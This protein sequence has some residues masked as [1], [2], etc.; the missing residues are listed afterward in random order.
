[1][2]ERSRVRAIV[3]EYQRA[4]LDVLSEDLDFVMLYG[5]RA[6][7]DDVEGSDIDVLCVMKHP[8]DYGELIRRTSEITGEISLKYGVVL[9]RVF[10]SREDYRAKR[11]PFL[12]NVHKDQIAI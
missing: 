12:V 5:S 3:E 8:F 6:R 9:S 1:M 2:V 4:L 10:V 7:G 11:S